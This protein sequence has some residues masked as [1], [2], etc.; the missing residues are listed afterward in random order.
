MARRVLVIE[1]DRTIAIA[2]ADRLRA[3]GFAVDIAHDGPTG[4]DACAKIQPDLVVLDLMLPGLDGLEVC[5]QIQRARAVPVLMLTARDG[6][7]D[8]LVGLG[9]GADDYLTKPFS[10]RELVARIRAI[11]RRVDL[12]GTSAQSTE[13]ELTIGPIAI[14]LHRRRQW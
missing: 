1:D 10:P 7:T 6:E 2:V 13:H 3:E 11:L 4:V 5:R 9:V 8:M 12:A 14:D